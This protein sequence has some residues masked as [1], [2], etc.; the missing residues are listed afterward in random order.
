MDNRHVAA[1]WLS[2]YKIQ[3]GAS[4]L[5]SVCKWQAVVS[6]RNPHW[7]RLIVYRFEFGAVRRC[8]DN[9]IA[10]VQ[11]AVHALVI[12]LVMTA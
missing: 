8:F 3:C 7:F 5:P 11:R 10:K 6:D 12:E 4:L 9:A 2:I 1:Q